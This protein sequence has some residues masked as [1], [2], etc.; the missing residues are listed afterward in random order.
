MRN[1]I[2]LITLSLLTLNTTLLVGQDIPS[3]VLNEQLIL[4]ELEKR[5]Y[6]DVTIDEL[7]N[8]AAL[9][10]ID[11]DKVDQYPQSEVEKVF[12]EILSDIESERSQN[13][14]DSSDEPNGNPSV[15]ESNTLESESDKIDDSEIVEIIK[16][17]IKISEDEKKKLVYGQQIFLNKNLEAYQKNLTVKPPPTYKLGEGDEVIVNIFGESVFSGSFT[18]QNGSIQPNKMGKIFLKG[19]T[20]S[21]ANEIIRK[22]FSRFYRFNK[23]QYNVTLNFSRNILVNVTGSVRDFGPHD[24]PA[25]NTAFSALIAAK[26]PDEKGSVRNIRIFRGSQTINF[27]LYEYLLDPKKADDYFLQNN[28]YVHVP[29]IGKVVE[30]SGAIN[31]PYKYELKDGEDLKDL[32]FW[33]GGFTGNAY[34]KSIQIISF[35]DDKEKIKTINYREL[36]KSGRNYKLNNGD[37]VYIPPIPASFRNFVTIEG[38]VDLPGE[39][40]FVEGM[41]ISDILLRAELQEQ[42]KLEIGYL[43]RKLPNSKEEVIR[44][45]IGEVLK[46]PSSPKNLELQ[47]KDRIL[48]LSNTS[49]FDENAKVVVT[50]AV[51]NPK[52]LNFTESITLED[53]INLSGGLKEGAT[54]KGY[55]FRYN[56]N[57]FE[58]RDYIQFD[59]LDAIKNPMDYMLTPKDSIVLYSY[60]DFREDEASVSIDGSVLNPSNY[61]YDSEMTLKDLLQLSGGVKIS[62]DITR[63]NVYRVN[64]E[65][66]ISTKT[67]EIQL[68]IDDNYNVIGAKTGDFP[69]LPYDKVLVRSAPDFELQQEITITGEVRYPGPYYITKPNERISDIIKRAG[70]YKQTAF[71]E[72][73]RIY[74]Q[75]DDLGSI[76]IDAVDI[77]EDPGN[78]SNYILK[79]GDIITVPKE[80]NFVSIKGFTNSDENLSSAEINNGGVINVP[81]I[82]GKNARFYIDEYAGGIDK[83]NGARY[84][85]IKVRQPSGK[86]E[87]TKDYGFVKKYPPVRK[88][89][90]II[91]ERR[92]NSE[93]QK[94]K[95]KVDWGEVIS[96]TVAQVTAILTLVILIQQIQ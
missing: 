6:E 31:R 11:L 69:L 54:G 36:E 90:T 43:Y 33:S 68:E 83:E 28:D 14:I 91:V 26:G 27:D 22:E 44:I 74:R 40:Q 75:E 80:S 4:A 38:A 96:N 45:S 18:I 51:R 60:D 57:S 56:P 81:F 46:S 84:S 66:G 72:G 41:K 13:D 65:N 62:A 61:S 63:V 19:I 7:K 50:G 76:V 8:R 88:G 82:E 71:R 5:G 12:D 94:E 93:E 47:S 25:S 32:L 34:Q 37:K 58:S 48:I 89:A 21:Q 10:G 87:K 92:V 73:I 20:L 23:D 59:A 30:I 53:A 55:I 1:F 29:I 85:L 15:P 2:F 95:E 77:L 49:F 64:I 39:I 70:G 52:K 67:E 3:S 9:K 78:P 79:N 24:I 35:E 17:D 42:A 16:E 86:I